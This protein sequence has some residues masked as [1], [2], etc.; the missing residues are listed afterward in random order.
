MRCKLTIKLQTRELAAVS[1]RKVLP[2]YLAGGAEE[3]FIEVDAHGGGLLNPAWLAAFG[4]IR[5]IELML[6]LDRDKID[7]LKLREE[8]YLADLDR[9]NA[10]QNAL[11]FDQCVIAWRT[12]IVDGDKPMDC[13]RESFLELAA[14]PVYEL[15]MAFIELS[16]AILGA[17]DAIAQQAKADVKN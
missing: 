16:N 6:K 13:T 9:I 3:C 17:G 11:L 4:K 8:A 5:S 12:N 15:K 2:Q 10:A 1:F 7:D 14:V